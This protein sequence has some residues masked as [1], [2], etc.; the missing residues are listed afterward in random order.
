MPQGKTKLNIKA[1]RNLRVLR[2]LK[3]LNAIPSMRRLVSTLLSSMPE[4]LNV[5]IFLSFIFLLFGILG[6]QLFNGLMYNKCRLTE[7]P[8]NDT[9]WPVVPDL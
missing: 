3:S 5:V 8:V 2:P 9:Y 4:L 7:R 6:T 1:F